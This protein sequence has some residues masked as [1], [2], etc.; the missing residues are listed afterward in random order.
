MRFTAAAL[1][2]LLA[3]PLLAE[4]PTPPPLTPAATQPSSGGSPS[5][6]TIPLTQFEELRKSNESTSATVVDMMTISGTFAAK[7]LAVTLVGR[8]VGTR[9]AAM[10]VSDAPDLTLSGCSGDAL[11]LRGSKGTYQLLPLAPSF[12]LRCDARPSGSDRLALNV[13]PLVLAVRSAVP[14]GELVTGDE[15][16]AGAR[17]YRLVRQVVGSA[18][19]LATTAT[20]R[21]LI[22]LLPDTSRFRYVIQVHNPNRSTAPLPL[23]LISGEHLQQIDSSAPYEPN[24]TSYEFA[25]PPGDSTITL[26]GELQGTSFA[27]PVEASLQYVVVE[28]HPLLRPAFASSPKRVSTGETGISTQ[29]RG[30]L[31]FEIGPR[32]RI[33]WSVTRLEAMRAISYAIHTTSHIFFIPSS[34]PVLGESLLSLD[35]QGAPEL[36]L[37]RKPEPTFVSL[38]GEPVL[39]TKNARGELTVPLSPGEQT[40]IVQHRQPVMSFPLLFAQLDVPGLPVPSTYTHVQ[41]RYPAHWLPLWESFATRTNLWHPELA[42]CFLFLLLAIWIERVLAFLSMTARRRIAAALL[43]AFAAMIVPVVLWAIVVA[44]GFVTAVWIA[45]RRMKLSPARIVAAVAGALLVVIIAFV[46]TASRRTGSDSYAYSGSGSG[47]LA[48]VNRDD[49]VTTDTAASDVPPPPAAIPTQANTRTGDRDAYQGLPAKFE[50]PDGA[51]NRSFREQMLS[52]ERPHSV[53]LVLLSMTLVTWTSIAMAFVAALLLWSER[54]TIGTALRIR[55]AVA[56]P[57]APEVAA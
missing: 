23:H 47:G 12:T 35:N 9:T 17:G 28:S 2:A 14:D 42:D 16:S 53:T 22:T 11:L 36:V 6:V 39:M 15:D 54:K 1:C 56:L 20:G 41:L 44:C 31:A 25:M 57:A 13:S 18:E 40:L 21:Y 38:A 49:S 37:P 27:P 19:K 52:P 48:S 24:G 51:R 45:S 55:I 10:V 32:E 43:L 46:Y 30:A 33:S 7:N 3:A 5:S 29:Y 8:S 4:T 26:S 50:L 34:G